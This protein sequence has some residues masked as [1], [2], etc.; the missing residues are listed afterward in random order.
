MVTCREL[1]EFLDDYIADALPAAVRREF[2][3]H[4]KLCPACREYLR[5]YRRTIDL[6]RRSLA[7]VD[8]SEC[9]EMPDD[10]VQAI[11]TAMSNT[12]QANQEEP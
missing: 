10:L 11:V 1:I 12:K 2:E 5:T 6:E 7:D 8:P 4:L 3:W 9:D